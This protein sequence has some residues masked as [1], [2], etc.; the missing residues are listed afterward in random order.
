MFS[1][2]LVFVSGFPTRSRSE[3][4]DACH[5]PIYGSSGALYLYRGLDPGRWIGVLVWVGWVSRM[6]RLGEAFGRTRGGLVVIEL[7]S[8]WD[9][10]GGLEMGWFFWRG[11]LGFAG[12]VVVIVELCSLV[13]YVD[14]G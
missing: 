11:G 9:L 1:R 6:R 3:S 7:Y 14:V 4:C 13:L 12:G 10:S 5:L 8:A 2:F